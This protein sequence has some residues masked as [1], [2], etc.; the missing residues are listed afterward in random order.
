MSYGLTNAPTDFMDLMNW[1]SRNYLDS[2]VIFYIDDIWCILRVRWSCESFEDIIASTQG[3][4]LFA[5]YGTMN[6]GKDWLD[7]WS[8]SFKL[9]H[10]GWSKENG[11]S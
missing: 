8:H 2:F 7:S 4:V 11:S 6:F 10:R 5:K 1:V 9:G 3:N